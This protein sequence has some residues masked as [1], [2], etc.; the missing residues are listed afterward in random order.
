[1][2]DNKFS[3]R[4]AQALTFHAFPVHRITQNPSLKMTIMRFH[5]IHAFAII[6]LTYRFIHYDKKSLAPFE[7]ILLLSSA[8]QRDAESQHKCL[9]ISM[10]IVLN[11]MSSA[12][13][14]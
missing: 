5:M 14:L 2:C 8:V 10:R 12:M 7:I 1:M 4:L 3:F 6:A 9:N 11:V 13:C